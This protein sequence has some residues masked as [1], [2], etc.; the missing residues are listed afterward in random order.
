MDGPGCIQGVLHT[1]ILGV[2]CG[3][4]LTAVTS[5]GAVVNG[6]GEVGSL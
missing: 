5:D 3:L 6:E 4:L 2:V 1:A